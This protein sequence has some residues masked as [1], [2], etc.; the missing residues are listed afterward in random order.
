MKPFEREQVSTCVGQEGMGTESR[1]DAFR[2][3]IDPIENRWLSAMAHTPGWHKALAIINADSKFESKASEYAAL[4]KETRD[5]MKDGCAL[6]HHVIRRIEDEG[7]PLF[8]PTDFSP[9]TREMLEQLVLLVGDYGPDSDALAALELLQSVEAES[10]DQE[11][12]TAEST[13]EPVQEGD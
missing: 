1:E 2:N 7:V 8:D 11:A 13:R 9:S 12:N 10:G 6:N 4:P 3:A 5:L